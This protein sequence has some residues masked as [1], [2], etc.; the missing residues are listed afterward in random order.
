L[1]ILSSFSGYGCVQGG[2][3]ALSLAIHFSNMEIVTLLLDRGA[4]VNQADDVS[5]QIQPPQRLTSI[6]ETEGM[7]TLFTL[8]PRF[9]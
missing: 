1:F 2:L 4:D 9:S 8:Q 3:D 7:F 6:L 5:I